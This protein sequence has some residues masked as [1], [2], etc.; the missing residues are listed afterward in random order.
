M[1]RVKI[2]SIHTSF[3]SE[4]ECQLMPVITENLPQVYVDTTIWN[5]PR[6]I[7]LADPTFNTP[8]SIDLLIGGALFWQILCMEQIKL[9]NKL[10]TLQKTM[11]GWVVGGEI[12]GR[13]TVRQPQTCHLLTK[14]DKQLEKFWIIEKG[15]E[16]PHLSKQEQYCEE[17]FK[18]TVRQNAEGRYI[19]RLP[20]NEAT[21]IGSSEEFAMRRLYSMENR[22]EK[23]PDIWKAYNEFMTEYEAMGHMTPIQRTDNSTEEEAFYLP[24]QPVIRTTSLTTKLRIIFDASAK[25]SNGTSLNDMLLIDP[26]LQGDLRSIMLRFRCHQYVMTADIAMMFRQVMVSEEDRHLQRILWREDSDQ[27]VQTYTLNTVT[28][29]TACAPYLA[30]RCLRHL[31]EGEKK[32]YPA[33][34]KILEDDFYMDDVLTGSDTIEGAAALQKELSELL[35]R[36]QFPLRKWRSNDSRVLHH[37]AED[38]KTDE[39]FVLD[40]EEPLKTLGL[41]W[42]SNQD[43]LQYKVTVT[44]N[45]KMSKRN[46]LS[47][48]ASIYD[49][50]GLIGPILITAKITMQQLWKIKLGWDEIVSDEISRAWTNYYGDLPELNNLRIPR[51]VNPLNETQE[52]DLHGFGDSSEKAYGACIYC[53]YKSRDGAIKSFLLCS[54]ARVAPLKTI[55]LPKLE[56]CAALLLTRL[57]ANVQKAMQGKIRRI[58]LWSDST[59]FLCWI[60]T[61]P[62]ELKT[63]YANRVAEIQQLLPQAEWNHVGSEQNPADLLSRGMAVQ[64]FTRNQ[65]WWYGLQWITNPECWPK[66]PLKPVEDDPGRKAQMICLSVQKHYDILYKYSVFSK[67]LRVIAYCLCIAYCLRFRSK[68]KGDRRLKGLTVEE[69]DEAKFVILRLVQEEQFA[70][71]LKDLQ[72]KQAVDSKSSLKQLNLFIDN[73]GI[74]IVGGRLRHSDIPES[75]RHPIVLPSRHHITT[76][77][78]REQHTKLRHCGPQQLLCVTRLEYWPLSGRREARKITRA[79]TKAV[80]LELVSGLDTEAFM[81]ALRRFSARRGTSSHIYSDNGSNFIGASNELKAMYEFLRREGENIATNLAMQ[82]IC[83]HFIPPHSPHFGGLW[84]AG[85]KKIEGI[86]NSRPLTPMSSDP[87]DYAALTLSHFITGDSL[88][89]PA[90]ENYLDVPDMRLSR[91]QHLQ[92]IR[93]HFWQRWQREYLQ[94][95]QVRTKWGT[96][97]HKM[98]GGSLVI[99]MDENLPTLQWKLGRITELHPG[100]D[101]LTRV[102]TVRTSAGSYKRAVKK[103]CALPDEVPD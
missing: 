90:V 47:Q 89:R 25:T 101:G 78:L 97:K 29:G 4:F 69:L 49:P 103:L 73:R 77:I 98:E 102:V 33:A 19:V 26:N 96:G 16:Q 22:I 41:L 75:Q 81:A 86:L 88:L 76:I 51:N 1:V 54:R 85:V 79:C 45:Q 58:Y 46:I 8:G 80:H 23:Q 94:Q 53:T 37:L 66:M 72:R 55:S 27:A 67:L 14:L 10:P 68:P 63:F 35:A 20:R 84:E 21:K 18:K 50:L 13:N 32:N 12:V 99:L 91:W 100:S 62:Y 61:P 83:W 15:T 39:L 59:I 52:I 28:N 57:S 6:H 7:K 44:N 71:K 70:D 3:T 38:R 2:K 74:I 64:E 60:K 31:A 87:N 9:H 17:F 5:V 43:V 56:L 82:H 65:L 95:L 24:H 36:G 40:K 42:N 48:I 30:M 11:L 93:Q 34:A 92:K